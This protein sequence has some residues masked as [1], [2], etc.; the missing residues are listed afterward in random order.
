MKKAAVCL[1][2]HCRVLSREMAAACHR[3]GRCAVCTPFVTAQREGLGL[4]SDQVR[5]GCFARTVSVKCVKGRCEA[6]R[7][8]PPRRPAWLRAGRRHAGIRGRSERKQCLGV[9]G[10]GFELMGL[11][12]PVM[13]PVHTW[14]IA[15]RKPH[16]RSDNLSETRA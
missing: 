15:V 7:M 6:V 9:H 11:G 8:A 14:R 13:F 12:T 3:A 2:A 4:R 5:V 1:S 16:Y 10:D